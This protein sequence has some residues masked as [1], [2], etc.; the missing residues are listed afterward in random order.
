M[1]NELIDGLTKKA[2]LFTHTVAGPRRARL[3]LAQHDISDFD[4]ELLRAR[5]IHLG[6]ETEVLVA[7]HQNT[8]TR[9]ASEPG[10]HSEI[11]YVPSRSGKSLK[12]FC[13]TFPIRGGAP[14]SSRRHSDHDI[15]KLTA[16]YVNADGTRARLAVFALGTEDFGETWYS[17]DR[18]N[19]KTADSGHLCRADQLTW[20]V[21]QR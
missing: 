3:T 18:G 17:F 5:L 1:A 13:P 2:F 6:R 19:L 21:R 15:P 14:F 4:E 12:V 11:R 9:A 10:I 8:Q 20:V 7:A 16:R